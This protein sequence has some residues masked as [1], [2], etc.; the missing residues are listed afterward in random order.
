MLD[1]VAEETTLLKGR[2]KLEMMADRREFLKKR[3]RLDRKNSTYDCKD[4]IRKLLAFLA[5][6]LESILGKKVSPRLL[7]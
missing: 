5:L 3:L 7:V 2:R 6:V 1:V 4:R